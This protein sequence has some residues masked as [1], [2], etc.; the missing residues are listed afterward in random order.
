[1]LDDVLFSQI[2]QKFPK[3]KKVLAFEKKRACPKCGSI[4]TISNRKMCADGRK[5]LRCGY[6]WCGYYANMSDKERL[7]RRKAF[8]EHGGVEEAGAH[9]LWSKVPK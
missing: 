5:C 8:L 7:L 4:E 1:M 2:K 9:Y 3:N 6:C